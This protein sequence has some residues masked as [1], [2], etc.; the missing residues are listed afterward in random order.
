MPEATN[1]AWGAER[2]ALSA[3]QICDSLPSAREI[4]LGLAESGKYPWAE[5]LL[6]YGQA[7]EAPEP[8]EPDEMFFAGRCYENSHRLAQGVLRYVEGVVV[9]P[10]M[11]VVHAWNTRSGRNAR[12]LDVSLWYGHRCSYWGVELPFGLVDEIL[13]RVGM[14]G[15]FAH[16]EHS[17][18]SICDF[19]RAAG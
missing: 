8:P 13:E 3:A 16:W 7:F 14:F 19:Y 18:K 1:E 17:A 6:R 2:A 9:T 4:V 11:P 5:F 10:Y 15:I 12:V